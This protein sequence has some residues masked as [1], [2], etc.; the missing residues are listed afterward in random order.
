[1]HGPQISESLGNPPSPVV[2][3]EPEEPKEPEEP[4]GRHRAA[5]KPTLRSMTVGVGR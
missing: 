2:P 4:D 3:E 1:M 5:L